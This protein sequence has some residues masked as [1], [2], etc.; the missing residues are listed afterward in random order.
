MQ[1]ALLDIPETFQDHLCERAEMGNL[2]EK[3]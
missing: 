2:S 1:A 3:K